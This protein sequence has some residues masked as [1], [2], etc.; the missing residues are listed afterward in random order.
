MCQDGSD[1]CRTTA[2]VLLIIVNL[3]FFLLGLLMLAFGIA[4]VA[5]PGK[6]INAISS[7]GENDFDSFKDASDGYII[8]LVRAVGIFMIVLGGIVAIIAAFGF[9]G[10]CCE[11]RCMLITYVVILIIIVL[12]EVALIIFA[13][14]FPDKFEKTGKKALFN[15]LKAD[16]EHDFNS[17]TS[18]NFQSS[19]VG[20]KSATW[21]A[22]QWSLKCCGAYD[23][24]D[25]QNVT[26]WTKAY[27]NGSPCVDNQIVPS[28][29]C[30][31]KNTKKIPTGF[32][33]YEN[34]D[35]CMKSA[36]PASTNT[37][38]CGDAVKDLI[39]DYSKIAIGIAAAVV[40]LELILITLALIM[41]CMWAD[42]SGKYV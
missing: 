37:K 13:A 16:F 41:A 34:Y 26:G 30:K 32:S 29:C 20:T 2:K 17:T 22:I 7:L 3:L 6:C 11:S 38:G 33:D 40:G 24:K 9:F 19:D 14:V 12:A 36:D 10:A 23:Y 35:T 25:Y 1:C 15:S 5:A 4:L 27:C 8:D 21:N 39:K 42:R 28:S 18:D 31:R